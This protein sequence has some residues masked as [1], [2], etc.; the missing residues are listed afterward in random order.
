MKKPLRNLKTFIASIFLL[1]AFGLSGWGQTNFTATYNLSGDGNNVTSFSYNGTV[2]DGINPGDLIKIGITSSSSSNN[3]RGSNWP[4]GA[5]NGSDDFTGTIDLT[6][7]IGFTIEPVAGYKFTITSITFGVGR[8]ATGPRQ[9]EWR[10]NYD[11]FGSTL[12]N[13]TNLNAGLTNASG[14]LT[15]PDANSS[16]TGNEL[17]PAGYVDKE[18]AVEFRL[19]GYNSEAAGGTGGLQGNITITGTFGPA[20]P[21]TDPPVASFVPLDEATNVLVDINPVITFDEVIY[22]TAGVAVD[23]SNVEGLITFK[24]TDAAGDDVAFSATIA[25]G[26]VITIVPAA[27]LENEQLYYLAVA[28]VEDAAGNES[29]LAKYHIYHSR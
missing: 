25:D 4:L 21:D 7:Y 17:S 11:G 1:L 22:T 27:E 24:K 9:W 26:K 3:F 14:V 18:T 10:G 16:W 13:Y 28:P 23:N 29:Y 5:T 6:K 15:N 20:G 2:Y 8:S 12:D 19:Y